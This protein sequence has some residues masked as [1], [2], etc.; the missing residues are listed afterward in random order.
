[1][2]PAMAGVGRCENSMGTTKAPMVVRLPHH[3]A[4]MKTGKRCTAGVA[5]R[6]LAEGEDGSIQSASWSYTL[7]QGFACK[8]SAAKPVQAVLYGC[9]EMPLKGN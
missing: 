6:G 8:Q 7:Q 4:A 3:S 1:M 2:P 9:T 5:A